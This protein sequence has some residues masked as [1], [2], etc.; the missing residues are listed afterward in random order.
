MPTTVDRI[1]VLRDTRTGRPFY[2]CSDHLPE[3]PLIEG[4]VSGQE[5]RVRRC[6]TCKATLKAA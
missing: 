6:N 4:K 2:A 3:A 1:F 5:H